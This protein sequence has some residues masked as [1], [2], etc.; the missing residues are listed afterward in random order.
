MEN[1]QRVDAATDTLAAERAFL[2]S[3]VLNAAFFTAAV[4]LGLVAAAA[5]PADTPSNHVLYRLIQTTLPPGLVGLAVVG[6][7]AAIMSTANTMLMVAL[8]VLL[9]DVGYADRP[10]L[11]Q[12]PGILGVTRWTTWGVGLAG[13]VVGALEPRIVSLIQDAL[14][15]SGMLLPAV[16]GGLWW[17]R[18]TSTGALWSIA[19]GFPL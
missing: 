5:L 10:K 16:I 9:S 11:G 19:V 6:L 17:R 8:A 2:W 12:V 15:G 3:G 7:F 4:T 13:L 18:A 14:W 1:W